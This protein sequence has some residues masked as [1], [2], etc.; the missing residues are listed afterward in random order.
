MDAATPSARR[1]Y[2][3]ELDAVRFL[4]FLLVFLFHILPSNNDLRVDHL[5]RSFA[6]L[7]Y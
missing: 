3:P 7:F 1:Y 6:P 2:R 5:L 4:A